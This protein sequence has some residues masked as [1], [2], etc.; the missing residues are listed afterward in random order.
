MMQRKGQFI[1]NKLRPKLLHTTVIDKDGVEHD[2]PYYNL[3]GVL[4]GISDEEFEEIEKE[5]R[6]Y[7]LAELHPPRPELD[8]G[9]KPDEKKWQN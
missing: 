9:K 2:F 8:I 4:F 7:V 6:K 3:H 1:F 5:Y